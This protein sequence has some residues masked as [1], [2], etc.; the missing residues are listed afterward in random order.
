MSKVLEETGQVYG[1]DGLKKSKTLA[2]VC[3]SNAER[4]TKLVL[5][6]IERTFAFDAGLSDRSTLHHLG[7]FGY[8]PAAGAMAVLWDF[9]VHEQELAVPVL[10][11]FTLYRF[12]HYG[13]PILEKAVTWLLKQYPAASI[14]PEIEKLLRQVVW[15][16][17]DVGDRVT[18][19][20]VSREWQTAYLS[21]PEGKWLDFQIDEHLGQEDWG[22]L[23]GCEFWTERAISDLK[24]VKQTTAWTGLLQHCAEA[25]AGK[26]SE[27]WLKKGKQLL[28]EVGSAAFCKYVAAWFALVEK[29]RNCPTLG[30]V[31]MNVDEQQRMHERNAIVLKGLVWLCS[32]VTEADAEVNQALAAIALS[33]PRAGKVGNAAVFSL[34]QRGDVQAIRQLRLLQAQVKSGAAQKEIARA[35]AHAT[36]D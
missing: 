8:G 5:A 31:W 22:M 26:P 1:P 11:W 32:I 25:N 3:Q 13:T 19:T 16:F 29:G 34:R 12:N 21:V 10:E 30:S 20:F 36:R 28:N 4:R 24:R 27:K 18:Q 35:L 14:P 33:G 15:Q 2:E 9:G 6:L 23:A 17:R 7:F